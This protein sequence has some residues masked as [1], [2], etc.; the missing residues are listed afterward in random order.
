MLRGPDD[1]ALVADAT[2]AVRANPALA[3]WTCYGRTP[4]T[5]RAAGPATFAARV[6]HALS[7]ATLQGAVVAGDDR[8]VEVHARSAWVTR[9]RTP[10]DEFVAQVCA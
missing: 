9:G 5:V 3:P 1:L 6:A 8:A 4:L 2:A 10:L 7:R